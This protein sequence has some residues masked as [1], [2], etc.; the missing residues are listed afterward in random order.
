M[1]KRQSDTNAKVTPKK[2]GGGKVARNPEWQAKFLE[3]F[4]YSLNIV[5]SAKGA[6]VDRQTVYRARRNDPNFATAMDDAREEAIERLE[7][8]AY[9]RAG[10]IS[11]TLLI[12]LLK[13]HKPNLYRENIQ[14]QHAGQVEIVVRREEQRNTTSQ[15]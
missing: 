2:R 9:D 6:G 12:F 14:Q 3:L 11:D 15:N 13:A 5:G 8:Q 4:A 1:T 7:A 10:K